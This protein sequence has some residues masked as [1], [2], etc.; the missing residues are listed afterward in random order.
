MLEINIDCLS[1]FAQLC[2]AFIG[3]VGHYQRDSERARESVVPD[4]LQ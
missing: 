1:A 2:I 4:G 3:G